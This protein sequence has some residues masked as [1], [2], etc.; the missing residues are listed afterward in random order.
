MTSDGPSIHETATIDDGALIGPA[1]T[2]WHHAHI[3]SSARIGSEC[4]IGK[5]VYVDAGVSLGDRC[6]V[7]NGAQLY[8]YATV[9]PGVFIGP[10]AILTND[11]LP[12]AISPDGARMSSDDW[13]ALTTTIGG[14][15]SIGAGAIILSGLTIGAWSMVGAGSLLTRSLPAHALAYGAP[16]RVVGAICRCGASRAREMEHLSCQC[17]A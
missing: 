12:R 5:G 4:T 17:M 15:S 9:G 2:I 8:R 10:G 11:R 14:G 7:Q 3:R 13:T 1:T 16:A 6:K